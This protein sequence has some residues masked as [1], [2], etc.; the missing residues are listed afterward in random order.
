M[1][2]EEH[3]TQLEDQL[4]ELRHQ[5]AELRQQLTTAQ[6]DQWRGRVEDLELQMHLGA[7][8]ATDKVTAQLKNVHSKWAE[9]RRQ[10]EESVKTASSVADTVRVGLEKAFDDLHKALLESKRK[11]TS[12]GR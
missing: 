9:A 5:Q 11:L 4:R 7:V 8:D 6:F 10:F 3:I 12:S 2:M 1:T